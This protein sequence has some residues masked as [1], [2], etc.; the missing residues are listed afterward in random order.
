MRQTH[1]VLVHANTFP[2]K[3][4]RL[5]IVSAMPRIIRGQIL[6][7]EFL[8]PDPAGAR[9]P[10]PQAREL[11]AIL[12]R[13]RG[14]DGRN[15]RTVPI[16]PGSTAWML[17]SSALVLLMVPG[18]ALFYG[19]LVRRK[20][21]LTTMLQSFAAMGLIGVQWIV[22]GYALAFGSKGNAWLGWTR[23]SSPWPGCPTRRTTRTR[24]SPSWCS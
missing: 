14:T 24:P 10:G 9:G 8:T 19:G 17:V 3:T 6:N 22:I 4:V 1:A 18:L 11:R 7:C 23:P 2:R 16:D 13:Q 21:V 15:C 20:N 12:S 5:A